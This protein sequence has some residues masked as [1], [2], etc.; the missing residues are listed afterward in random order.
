[1]SELNRS[2]TE[3]EW[4]PRLNARRAITEAAGSWLDEPL[5]PSGKEVDKDRADEFIQPAKS[6]PPELASQAPDSSTPPSPPHNRKP[7]YSYATLVT[8]AIKSSEK[9]KMTLADIYTWITDNFPYYRVATTG[10]KNSVRHN[11]SLNKCFRKV[12]RTKDDPGK[13]SYW[14]LDPDY[15]PEDS[16]TKKKKTPVQRVSLESS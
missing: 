9:K 12:A 16:F 8:F 13:G 2:L 1:M 6:Y 4:L 14:A 10:W 7:A 3:M 5:E 15:P 11:L